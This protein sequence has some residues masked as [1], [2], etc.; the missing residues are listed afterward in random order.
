M[1]VNLFGR[2]QK[3]VMSIAF[4]VGCI[5]LSGRT[6]AETPRDYVQD[7]LI[8][9]WDAY[10]NDGAG[11]HATELTE[12][13]DT[14]G[15]YS[16]VF[17]TGSGI[18]VDGGALVFPGTQKGYATLNASN[19]DATFE[20]AK[21]GTCEIVILSEAT[22]GP[23]CALQSSNQS[24]ILLYARTRTAATKPAEVLTTTGSSSSSSRKSVLYN[25]SEGITTFATTYS[26]ALSVNTWANGEVLP[27]SGSDG[28]GSGAK[29]ATYLGHR[30][31]L[32]SGQAFKGKIYA[33]RLYSEQLT[34][35]QIA[36]NHAIDVARFVKG[37][38]EDHSSDPGCKFSLTPNEL[39]VGDSVAFESSVTGF[40]AATAV[41]SWTITKPD[42][43]EE[44][45]G[46]ANPTYAPQLLGDYSVTLVV[47][48]EEGDPVSCSKENCFVVSFRERAV[49]TVAE[50][51]D[52]VEQAGR[53]STITCAANTYELNGQLTLRKGV[54]LIGPGW[55]QATLKQTKSGVR[56]VALDHP[57][58]YVEG[59]TITGGGQTSERDH[60]C[61]VNISQSGGTL[62]KCRVIGNSMKKNWTFGAGVAMLGDGLIDH[63]IISNNAFTAG[64]SQFGGGVYAAR[65][66]VENCLICNNKCQRCGGG[67]TA[68]GPVTVRN[69]TIVGNQTSDRGGNVSWTKGS[70]AS[71]V[72]CVFARATSSPSDTT[73]GRPEWVC[74][75]TSNPPD[76]ETK[77]VA[78]F[79]HCI[80][81]ASTVTNEQMAGVITLSNPVFVDADGG[82]YHEQ[83][84]SPTKDAGIEYEGLSETDLDGF[85]R[86]SGKAVDVGCYEFDSS[87]FSVGISGP[88]VK[89]GYL[90]A[91]VAYKVVGLD[92]ADDEAVVTWHVVSPTGLETFP[93]GRTLDLTV[94]ECGTWTV[95]VTAVSG[96]RSSTSLPE[97]YYAIQ[98]KLYVK[99][100]TDA[101]IAAAAF[102]FDSWDNAAVN[103]IDAIDAA[104]DGCTIYLEEGD[105][106]VEERVDVTKALTLVGKSWKTTKIRQT[107][108][109]RPVLYVNNAGA[110]VR[111]VTLTGMR[112]MSASSETS[113]RSAVFIGAQG[114]TVE[115][116]RITGNVYD[117]DKQIHLAYGIGIT[118][119]GDAAVCRRCIIDRNSASKVDGAAANEN[120]GGGVQGLAGLIENCLVCFNTNRFAAG[121]YVNAGNGGTFTVR[122]CTVYGNVAVGADHQEWGKNGAGGIGVW[123]GTANI[124]NSIFAANVST[125]QSWSNGGE[126]EWR[127]VGGSIQFTNCLMPEGV[128]WPAAATGCLNGTPQF[129]DVAEDNFRLKRTSLG[130]DAGKNELVRETLD[131]ARKPRI[132]P[133]R[134]GIVDMGCYENQ[135]QGLIIFLR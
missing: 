11:G 29:D 5:C 43:T 72:N 88:T 23:N 128:S 49:A 119:N 133:A 52:A 18:T 91:T 15:T 80:F 1:Q 10:E 39:L 65:G 27:A 42:G 131:L 3:C 26:S 103:V 116:C 40:D 107:A 20:L 99:V 70:D 86:V 134:P 6:W 50:L 30:A 135:Q 22:T 73:A 92:D 36:E 13:K 120:R 16:F 125:A 56:V 54:R 109:T 45:L 28:Y 9:M 8:A 74:H 77:T 122:N 110:T 102:P 24:G 32:A 17:T 79:D 129:I 97:T 68:D 63:C 69:C 114:G 113:R 57:E 4:C 94:G 53:G 132:A 60:G 21:N 7:G 95:S 126:P 98:R 44:K 115:D 81:P 112:A 127:V 71:F 67:L 58:A 38:F 31:T 82:D 78:Q 83:T 124:E 84:S 2:L 105:H 66:R 12:W 51:L 100:A 104:I 37:D 111:G 64:V 61:G 33:I 34:P 25:W 35:E 123:T 47:T 106:A 55:D 101:S 14:S 62:A 108:T 90:G 130:I 75:L 121:I 59:F 85:D 96:D 19:T 41:Y 76:T 48:P 46:G 87:E 89:Q 117:A 118:L 93:T